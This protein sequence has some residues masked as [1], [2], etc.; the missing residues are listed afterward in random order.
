MSDKRPSDEIILKNI[1]YSSLDMAIAATD[2]DFRILYYNPAAERI[3][4]YKA[5]EVI[6]KTVMEMHT[7]EKVE[8]ER[9]EKAIETVRKEGEYRYNVEQDKDS[10]PRFIESRVSGIWDGEERLI[11]FVLMSRDITEHKLT[12]DSLRSLNDNFL[13]LG[14]DYNRNISIITETCGK[15]LGAACSI[16]NKLE[17]ETLYPLGKWQTPEDLTPVNKADGRICYDVIKRGNRDGT[18]IVKNLPETDYYHTDPNVAAYG[19]KTYVG[20]SVYCYGRSVGALCAVYQK[21]IELDRHCDMVLG[22]LS[23]ALGIEEERRETQIRQERRL[24]GMEKLDSSVRRMMI[25][26]ENPEKFYREVSAGIVEL[27]GADLSAIPLINKDRKTFT[28]NGA[29]GEKADMLI[30]KTIPLDKGGLCGWVASHGTGVNVKDLST[31]PRVISELAKALDVT[32]AIL[33]PLVCED[34][35]IGGL[36]AFRKGEPFDEIDEELLNLY[37]QRVS[38]ALENMRILERLEM[39]VHERT[40]EQREIIS[41]M[42]GREVRMGELKEVIKKLREQLDRAGLK[43]EVDDPLSGS[44]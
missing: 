18:Y 42:S 11:G 33:S 31:D 24:R 26:V 2:L 22:I 20:R 35:V 4:G 9:F 7:K 21:D 13:D 17:G 28:Y 25:A 34:R 19:L 37:A 41:A 43:P 12:E 36:S 39:T 1:L 8:P 29:E 30:G 14:P 10:G 32:S 3:F 40:V 16:Y 38:I 27:T 15:L 5:E 23:T 44:G 6:G